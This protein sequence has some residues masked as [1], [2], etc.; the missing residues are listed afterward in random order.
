MMIGYG[1]GD[2]HALIQGY[3]GFDELRKTSDFQANIRKR[4]QG[5]FGIPVHLAAPVLRQKRGSKKEVQCLVLHF[6]HYNYNTL[7]NNKQEHL[8]TFDVK[9]LIPYLV[10][11]ANIPNYSHS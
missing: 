1:L 9:F 2:V 4:L 11:L 10:K 3:S 5:G 8:R 6:I 7:K